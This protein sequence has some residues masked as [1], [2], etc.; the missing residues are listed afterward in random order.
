MHQ[1]I[2]VFICSLLIANT[3]LWARP[4]SGAIDY[5]QCTTTD[6]DDQQWIAKNTYER[7]AA[8]IAYSSCKKQSRIP[9]TCKAAKEACEHMINGLT[10]K[11]M[12]QCTALDKQAKP[13]VSN[14]YTQRYDAALAA[15]AYCQERSS[16]PGTCY[17]NLLT[18]KNKNPNSRI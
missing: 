4:Q 5:W 14:L 3:S 18:C 6:N 9:S 1:W 12:W 7:A 11:P 17:I 8:N 16:E 15:K 13:W 10:D 2:T